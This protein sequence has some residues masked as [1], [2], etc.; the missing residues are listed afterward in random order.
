MNSALVDF[1]RFHTTHI[2]ET[3][4][5]ILYSVLDNWGLTAKVRAI[6]TDNA[7]DIVCG[8]NILRERLT[9]SGNENRSAA[10]FHVRSF[11]HVVNLAVKS[12]LSI[13]REKVAAIRIVINSTLVNETTRY[14]RTRTC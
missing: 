5:T 14:F 4:A 12:C 7:A 1:V 8:I 2:G 10:N 13:V 9:I 3:T 11:A 6:V